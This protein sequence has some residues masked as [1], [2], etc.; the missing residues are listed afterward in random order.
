MTTSSGVSGF[1]NNTN[2]KH[3]N[4]EHKIKPC[5]APGCLVRWKRCQ[6]ASGCN[7]VY[8]R[9]CKRCEAHPAAV[10]VWAWDTI[11]TSMSLK[12]FWLQRG[13][14]GILLRRDKTSLYL[15]ILMFLFS[16]FYE[17]QIRRLLSL[18]TSQTYGWSHSP[19][20]MTKWWLIGNPADDKMEGPITR[21]N[22]HHFHT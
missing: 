5:A 1:C 13:F 6:V 9:I 4:N 2:C 11:D 16:R 21:L 17:E 3:A 15:D 18:L 12:M 20:W 10:P 19:Q 8:Y 22:F 7:G 14:E